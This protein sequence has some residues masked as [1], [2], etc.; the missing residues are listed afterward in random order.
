MRL[1]ITEKKQREVE[2]W[3]KAFMYL[4]GVGLGSATLVDIWNTLGLIDSWGWA[5][6]TLSV[7][8]LVAATVVLCFEAKHLRDEKR[9][10]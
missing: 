10:S 3:A 1:K 7:L 8:L 6:Q 5:L 4:F 9:N 2:Y